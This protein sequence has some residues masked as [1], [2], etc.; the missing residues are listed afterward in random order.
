MNAE[1]PP[2]SPSNNGSGSTGP[3]RFGAGNRFGKGRPAGSRAKA[4][5]ALDAIGEE[6]AQNIVRALA[7]RA[8][9]GDTRAAELILQRA[10][11]IRKS[12]P[13]SIDIGRIE[14]AADATRAH[15]EVI[16]AVCS[17]HLTLDEAE[18]LSGL[19]TRHH[20]ALELEEIQ[21]RL[22]ALESRGTGS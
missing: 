8:E 18:G 12:R 3:F 11:P 5:L 14:T 15:S 9:A 21:A 13:F 16:E 20:A 17:G 19:L 6:R 7:E 4:V 1:D 10:W 2:D 22:A